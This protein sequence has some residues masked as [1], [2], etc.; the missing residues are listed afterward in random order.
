MALAGSQV[1]YGRGPVASIDPTCR[2]ACLALLSSSAL[3]ASW[4][5]CACLACVFFILLALSGL[6]VLRILRE[7]LFVV[8]FALATAALRAFG[9]IGATLQLVQISEDAGIFGLRLLAAYWAGRLFYASTRPSEI[10]D[11]ATRICRGFPVLR[12]YDIGLA[13]S[14]T[15]NYIPLIFQEWRD[16]AQAARSRGLPSRPRVVQV[17]P[18]IASFLR[19]L[20]LKAVRVPEALNARGWSASRGLAPMRWRLRDSMCLT[21]SSLVLL[22][23]ALRL[24]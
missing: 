22:C 1:G 19:R 18:M 15:L 24:V 21:V 8:V 7:T 23:C 14:L 20:M 10:R 4:I 17:I 11:S 3:L 2:L 9:S 12:R 16:T 5:L 6:S 13:I